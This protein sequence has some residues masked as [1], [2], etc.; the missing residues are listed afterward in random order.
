MSNS[1]P[2]T[3]RIA[4]VTGASRGIGAALAL[5]LAGAGAHI[6]AVARTVGGLE[7]LDDKIRAAGGAATLVPLD[8]KDH[9]G[10]ARLALALNERYGRLDVLVGNAGI[11]G[12]LSPLGHIDPKD[13]DNVLA[14][15]V[16]ANW[17][18]IRTMDVLL[19]RSQS[20]RAVLITS[21]LSW[22]GLAYCGPYAASKAALN[23]LVQAYASETESV[24]LK[25]NAFNPGPTRTRL[26]ASGWP[27]VD[28]DTL[29]TAEEVA[30]TIVPLCAE[31]CNETGKVYDFRAGRFLTFQPPV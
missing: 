15:N 11:L 5:Q 2:L 17:H 6:V 19:R 25:V 26:Y 22:R 7:E 20:G 4:L 12:P 28:P 23:A 30:K 18:L 8:V 31:P 27:G 21:G 9:D 1:F 14:I 13:W 24:G 29:P 3:N 16:T 10:I